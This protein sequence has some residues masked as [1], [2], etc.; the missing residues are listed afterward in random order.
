MDMRAVLIGLAFPS[1]AGGLPRALARLGI[2]FLQRLAARLDRRLVGSR[3][4]LSHRLDQRRQ[5]RLRVAGHLD[6]DRLEALEV[7][8][9]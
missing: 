1:V 7:L 2:S 6:V 5:R 4:R 3:Q 9:I 8:V